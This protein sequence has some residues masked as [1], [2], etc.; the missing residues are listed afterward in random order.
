MSV[1]DNIR[2]SVNARESVLKQLKSQHNIQKEEL[3]RLRT[4]A[5]ALDTIVKDQKDEINTLM[6]EKKTFLREHDSLKNAFHEKI[7]RVELSLLNITGLAE[8]KE[9]KIAELM[10][11]LNLTEEKLADLEALV[12]QKNDDLEKTWQKHNKII[13]SHHDQQA[14]NQLELDNLA[15]EYKTLQK[16]HNELQQNNNALLD[17]QK[18][19]ELHLKDL[20]SIEMMYND[21]KADLVDCCQQLNE[22]EEEN[23]NLQ[24]KCSE[25]ESEIKSYQQTTSDHRMAQSAN[26]QTINK[27]RWELN[28]V[29]QD[30]SNMVN[31]I[32]NLHEEINSLRKLLAKHPEQFDALQELLNQETAKHS[33]A[34]QLYNDLFGDHE[35]LKLK[36]AT[37]QGDIGKKSNQFGQLS[38][39]HDEHL[40][41]FNNLNDQHQLLAQT[42]EQLKAAHEQLIME[43]ATKDAHILTWKNKHA[44]AQSSLCEFDKNHSNLQNINEEL[45]IKMDRKNQEM[46][47]YQ[48]IND[49]HKNVAN[50][51][52]FSLA[53]SMQE[54][55]DLSK[56]HDTLLEKMKASSVKEFEQTLD[57]Q[58]DKFSAHIDEQ[59]AHM[60]Q[61]KND[62]DQ[63]EILY[64]DAHNKIENLV[65][66]NNAKNEKIDDQNMYITQLIQS[67]GQLESYKEKHDAKHVELELLKEN[68]STAEIHH[69]NQLKI[70]D[71]TMKEYQILSS[72]HDELVQKIRAHG[73]P[74]TIL[75]EFESKEES[76][77]ELLQQQHNHIKDLNKDCENIATQLND[78]IDELKIRDE[79]IENKSKM[80]ENLEF[81]CDKYLDDHME[82]NTLHDHLSNKVEAKNKELKI[83]KGKLEKD[84]ETHQSLKLSLS[85]TTMEHQRLK[86]NHDSLLSLFNADN[87]N[88][89]ERLLNKKIRELEDFVNQQ[90]TQLNLL[91]L[92]KKDKFDKDL[93]ELYRT[94]ILD[95]DLGSLKYMNSAIENNKFGALTMCGKDTIVN[96]IQS[97]L[98]IVESIRQQYED[99]VSSVLTTEML[100]GNF[101]AQTRLK[102]S[103]REVSREINAYILNI[104]N[105]LTRLQHKSEKVKRIIS[106]F[107][108]KFASTTST[109]QCQ[110]NL[111]DIFAFFESSTCNQLGY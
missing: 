109:G 88:E 67:H 76:L 85:M 97:E 59:D 6:L 43:S 90:N 31:T 58:L 64:N 54:H 39:T 50:E 23:K 89:F 111:D 80:I 94:E 108:K 41:R 20:R 42:H 32:D 33:S 81:R 30:A 78:T 92:N 83:H 34:K 19:Q 84:F 53:Q 73:D 86:K 77:K 4:N 7:T 60:I 5:I 75:I 101:G 35:A 10:D 16:N 11:T 63:L 93:E 15:E 21:V 102:M 96:I 25:F 27:L 91:Q 62:Y 48:R 57:E 52:Q 56:M 110:A 13:E 45:I 61:L 87:V 38:N 98:N 1:R 103:V 105:F 99:Y 47:E 2:K 18:G 46:L 14:R 17:N 44:S 106:G 65:S 9:L 71:K 107:K 79:L 3:S 104:T 12:H 70:H 95:N 66:K 40:Q 28:K 55:A 36:H 24:A 29:K 100:A 26:E 37:L 22:R 68:H 69:Q 8:R 49:L 72:M 51:F 74:E 82:L